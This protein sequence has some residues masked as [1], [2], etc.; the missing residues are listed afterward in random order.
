MFELI[1]YLNISFQM[2]LK[3]FYEFHWYTITKNSINLYI[4][5]MFI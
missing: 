1:L 2:L 5:E 3:L 4:I